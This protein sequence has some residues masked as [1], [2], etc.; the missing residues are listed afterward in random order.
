VGALVL[1]K[2]RVVS[3]DIQDA[4]KMIL[5]THRAVEDDPGEHH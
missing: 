5:A 2:K 1:E 3:M 4:A